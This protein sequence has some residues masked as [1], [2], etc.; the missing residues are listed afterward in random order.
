MHIRG[1]HYDIGTRT[2]EGLSS[3]PR[4]DKAQIET[5]VLDISQGLHANAI[6]IT[7]GDTN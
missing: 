4:L 2:I 7:G 6:R 3:R 5:E 1:I